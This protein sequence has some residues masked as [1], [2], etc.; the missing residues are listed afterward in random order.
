MPPGD[1]P[2]Y[3]PLDPRKAAWIEEMGLTFEGRGWP[4]TTGRIF[5][6]LMLSTSGEE[7]AAAMQDALGVSKGSV[8][9]GTRTL[10]TLGLIDRVGRR[11][12]RTTYYRM[13]P[14]A[15]EEILE[16]SMQL[17][18]NFCALL[19]R[20]AALAAGDAGPSARLADA[21]AFYRF[22]GDAM[23]DA[24]ARHHATR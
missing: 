23:R 6:Y 8:S 24:V 18:D 21:G 15:W 17:I 4:R 9:T 10:L 13:R 12:E 5:A 7:S 20:G 19:D 3:D 16:Q 1:E 22:I 14:G 2:R 11:G